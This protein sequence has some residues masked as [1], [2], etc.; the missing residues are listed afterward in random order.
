VTGPLA[1]DR[2]WPSPLIPDFS[3]MGPS[4]LPQHVP[5]LVSTRPVCPFI[6]FL[7]P[8]LFWTLA[9]SSCTYDDL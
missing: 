3:V 8:I 9:S 2:I 7:F 6:L 5:L 4:L 1:E